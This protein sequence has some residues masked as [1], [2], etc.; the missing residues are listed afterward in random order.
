MPLLCL[1]A[2]VKNSFFFTR[3]MEKS[4]K[5]YQIVG[6]DINEMNDVGLKEWYQIV[7]ECIKKCSER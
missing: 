6:S 3:F 1:E 7:Y 5:L 2:V 4:Q